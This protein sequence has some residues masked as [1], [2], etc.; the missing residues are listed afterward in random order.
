LSLVTFGNGAGNTQ[1]KKI[2]FSK[3]VDP[4]NRVGHFTESYLGS[5]RAN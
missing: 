1:G 3:S 4:P 5:G 2:L